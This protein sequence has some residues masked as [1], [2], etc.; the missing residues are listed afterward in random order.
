[1]LVGKEGG[2]H[3]TCGCRGG[4]EG[5]PSRAQSTAPVGWEPTLLLSCPC[6]PAPQ[7]S[8]CAAAPRV[9]VVR[10]SLCWDPVPPPQQYTHDQAPKHIMS[11]EPTM[12]EAR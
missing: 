6:T 12:S 8:L 10:K 1:M 11:G 2:S 5:P 7:S 3:W 9:P 4:H